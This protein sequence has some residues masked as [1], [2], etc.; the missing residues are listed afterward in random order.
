MLCLL[1]TQQAYARETIFDGIANA[2]NTHSQSVPNTQTIEVGFSPE[3]GAESL[4]LK[5]IR[6]A[7]KSIRV[8]AYSFTSK[9]IAEALVAAHKRGVDVR[10][11]LDKSKRTEKYTSANFIANS[12]IPTRID[13]QHAIAHNKVLVIDQQH[14]ETGSFNFT[15]AAAKRNAENAIVIWNNPELADVYAKDWQEHWQHSEELRANY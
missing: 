4:V 8:L 10:V 13:S 5:T 15:V 14:V 9:P 6:S 12:G 3:G 7:Q 11:V 1:L 2:W